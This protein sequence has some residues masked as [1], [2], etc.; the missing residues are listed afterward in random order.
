MVGH[1]VPIPLGVRF[2]RLKLGSF[3]AYTFMVITEN[4]VLFWPLWILCMQNHLSLWFKTEY[5]I[6]S[7]YFQVMF[8]MFLLIQS[9][10]ENHALHWICFKTTTI[11]ISI[12]CERKNKDKA[13][14]FEQITIGVP[15]RRCICMYKSQCITDIIQKKYCS[16]LLCYS[17]VEYSEINHDVLKVTCKNEWILSHWLEVRSYSSSRVYLLICFILYNFLKG[18]LQVESIRKYPFFLHWI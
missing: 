15:M 2:R 3:K 1:N 17:H 4:T 6:L 16:N 14:P 18:I 11:K 5:A 8:Q 7:S 12:L 9:A 13:L 10:T